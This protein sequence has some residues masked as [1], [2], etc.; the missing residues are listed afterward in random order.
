EAR[1][2]TE[3]TL[4]DIRTIVR[5]IFP[6]VL[7]DRGLSHAIEALVLDLPLPVELQIHLPAHTPASVESAVYF[8][9]SECLTNVVKH[10]VASKAFVTIQHEAGG[11]QVDVK[12]DG[13]GGADV[14]KGGGVGWIDETAGRIRGHGS[15]RVL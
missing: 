7:A 3:S 8:A 13:R 15:G 6:P 9:V 1:A 14:R 11:L 12:D 4:T 10:A 5:G 2:A